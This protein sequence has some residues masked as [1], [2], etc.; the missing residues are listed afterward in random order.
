V[1]DGGRLSLQVDLWR[2]SHVFTTSIG[3]IAEALQAYGETSTA[4]WVPS[5][6]EEELV[7]I[8]SVVEWLMHHGPTNA[9]GGVLFAKLEALAAIYVQEGAPRDTTRKRR[10]MRAALPKASEA[11]LERRPNHELASSVSE[12]Y[13]VGQDCRSFWGVR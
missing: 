9:S 10:D 7:R 11:A 1:S 2:L 12:E 8:C 6:S 4:E 13:G 3:R 5:C